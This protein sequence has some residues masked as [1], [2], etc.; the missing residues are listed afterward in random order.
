MS[1]SKDPFAKHTAEFREKAATLGHDVQELGKTTRDLAHDTVGMIRENASE[2]YQ[3]GL[4]KAQSLE[5]D[6]ET[7]IKEN[8]LQALLIAAGVGFVLGAL[9][10]RR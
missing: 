5:K 9:W 1:A 10:K 3:Q 7:K 8:P 4:K 6:L 2:Y